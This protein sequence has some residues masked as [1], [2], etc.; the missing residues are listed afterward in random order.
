[1]EISAQ[2]R[3]FLDR[4]RG[5]SIGRVVLG[6]LGLF[7]LL[8]PYRSALHVLLPL[9]FFVS[10]AV[11]YASFLRAPGTANFLRRRII[12]L[13]VPYYI[14][15]LMAFAGGWLLGYNPTQ[16]GW[17]D[18]LDILTL[19]PKRAQ[20]PFNVGQVWFIHALLIITLISP[21]LYALIRRGQLQAGLAI[22]A[23]MALAALQ[24]V[25]DIDHHLF[26]LRHNF[27]QALVNSAFFLFGGLCYAYTAPR[28]HLWPVAAVSA[29]LVAVA[30]QAPGFSVDFGDHSYAPDLYYMAASFLAICLILIAQK[31]IE[32]ALGHMR[33]VDALLLF[34]SKH[35]YSLLLAHS[36]Y[37]EVAEKAFGLVGVGGDPLR[38]LTKVAF[39]LVASALTAVPF[40]RLCSSVIKRLQPADTPARQLA[41]HAAGS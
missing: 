21:A 33:P 6:H 26:I 19:N 17:Q 15:M 18:F 11:G 5:V 1:M 39:V 9:L 32:A 40:T 3:L 28:R 29:A 10:G 24:L 7:W 20:T 35:S 36:L 2:D 23:I 34:C 30:T 31:P 16:F 27:Y 4:L 14:F 8:P 13:L 38:A 12:A 37:I 41:Q 22:A 25:Q